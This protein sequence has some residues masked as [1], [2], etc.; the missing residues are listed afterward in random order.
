MYH[1]DH[2]TLKQLKLIDEKKMGPKLYMSQNKF[3]PYP[4]YKIKHTQCR[5]QFGLF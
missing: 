4:Y 1:S 2:T 3:K 5:P